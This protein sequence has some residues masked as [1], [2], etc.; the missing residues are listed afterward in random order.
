MLVPDMRDEN[1]I[2][3]D[4]MGMVLGDATL[5]HTRLPDLP[6]VLPID[7]SEGLYTLPQQGKILFGRRRIQERYE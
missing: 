2:D 4:Q 6:A 5:H 3:E 1:G 7:K